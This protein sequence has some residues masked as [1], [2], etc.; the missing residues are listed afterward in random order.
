VDVRWSEDAVEFTFHILEDAEWS[1][2]EPVT[3]EDVVF[4]LECFVDPDVGSPMAHALQIRGAMDYSAGDAE[5]IEGIS[6]PDEK[7]VS[8]ELEEPNAVWLLNYHSLNGRG[9]TPKHIYGEIERSELE[10]H[11]LARNPEVGAGPFL[12]SR[13]ETEQFLE[14]TANEN[15]A[16]GAP[17]LDGIE[18]LL[19]PVDSALAE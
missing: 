3:A 17:N 1:D 2:G 10:G 12:L 11:E 14:F 5:S 13:W 19:M 18:L 16:H 15:Y 9:L 6:T 8:F 7:T 4:T